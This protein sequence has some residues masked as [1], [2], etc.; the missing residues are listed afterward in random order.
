[1]LDAFAAPTAGAPI[2]RLVNTHS[3]GDHFWGNQIVGAREIISTRA[4]AARMHDENPKALAAMGA[5][6]RRMKPLSRRRAARPRRAARSR[7]WPRSRACSAP[8][9]SAGS[10]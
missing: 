9:T 10:S 4:A 2:R 6:G 7:A 1:M 3:D 8:T 5:A